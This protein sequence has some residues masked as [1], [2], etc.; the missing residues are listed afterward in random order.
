MNDGQESAVGAPPAELSERALASGPGGGLPVPAAAAASPPSSPPSSSAAVVFNAAVHQLRIASDAERSEAQIAICKYIHDPEVEELRGQVNDRRLIVTRRGTA[1]LIDGDSGVIFTFHMDDVVSIDALYDPTGSP[2]PGCVAI[3]R[4]DGGKGVKTGAAG[5]KASGA[6]GLECVLAAEMKTHQIATFVELVV[7]YNPHLKSTN[8][9]YLW[10]RAKNSMAYWRASQGQGGIEDKAA[11]LRRKAEAAAK[12]DA[13]R[14]NRLL[15]GDDDR[16]VK[17][18]RRE[19]RAEARGRDEEE[20]KLRV[21]L[22]GG[23]VVAAVDAV[24]ALSSECDTSEEDDGNNQVIFSPFSQ[25]IIPPV[26]DVSRP[27]P[28][29]A[30]IG[31]R[32]AASVDETGVRKYFDAADVARRREM[33]GDRVAVGDALARARNAVDRVRHPVTHVRQRVTRIDPAAMPRASAPRL[34][35]GERDKYH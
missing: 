17:A 12:A 35:P 32:E 29:L 16:E 28:M 8:G 26:G 4:Q 10:K 15:F 34:S 3:E 23:D 11:E 2:V 5:A 13:D 14:L 21:L 9:L 6:P 1:M 19:L 25:G 27:M 7:R 30:A 31:F 22:L 24:G 20:R 33:H 18:R